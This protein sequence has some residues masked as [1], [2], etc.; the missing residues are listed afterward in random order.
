MYFPCLALGH[1][2]I[3]CM[4]DHLRDKRMEIDHESSTIKP[5]QEYLLEIPLMN[6]LFE[7]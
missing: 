6:L 2:K 4:R 7:S 3:S 5:G 1:E